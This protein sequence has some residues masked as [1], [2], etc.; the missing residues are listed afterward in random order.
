MRQLADDLEVRVIAEGIETA[1]EE[2]ALVDLGIRHHQGFFRG[3][4]M[5]LLDFQAHFPTSDEGY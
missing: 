3:E 4:P 2:N 5:P 1:E